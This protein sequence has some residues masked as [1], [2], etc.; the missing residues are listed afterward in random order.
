MEMKNG[1]FTA[2]GTPLDDFGM[3][4]EA[5]L[6]KE[7][8]LQIEAGVSGLLL[9]GTMG[10]LGCIPDRAYEPC[11]RIACDQ[12]AGRVPLLVGATDNSLAR[13]KDKLSILKQYPAFPTL[14]PPYYFKMRDEKLIPFFRTCAE[15]FTGPIFLYDHLPITKHKLNLEQV[16]ELA[17]IPNI[18]GIKSADIEMIRQLHICGV[19]EKCDFT[20]IISDISFFAEA[21]GEGIT[22]YLDGLF[23]CIPNSICAAQKLLND[24][25]IPAAKQVF[26][27]MI[28]FRD[29]LIAI[30]LWPAFRY[31]MNLLG[32][33]GNYAPDY[34]GE[35]SAPD[36]ERVK[37]LMRGM[38]E[39]A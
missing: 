9:M 18:A 37:D 25:D 31:A 21:F 17:L 10:M 28:A 2:L 26:G 39:L 15:M 14:M 16:K 20:P 29:E 3:I 35:L 27:R 6:R 33:S 38:G 11:V 19:E 24:G 5:S 13:V 7:I 22:H 4:D 23:S 34:E 36:R 12:V 32:C 8:E 1:F 30:D